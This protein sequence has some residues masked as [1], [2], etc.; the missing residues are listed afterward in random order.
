M[1]MRSEN[2]K[3]RRRIQR[4]ATLVRSVKPGQ[5]SVLVW[6]KQTS[7]LANLWTNSPAA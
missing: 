3:K 4:A 7:N 1:E 2:N 5:A 6:Q